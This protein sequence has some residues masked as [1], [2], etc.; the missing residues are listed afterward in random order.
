MA[1]RRLEG[2]LDGEGVGFAEI[3]YGD[4]DRRGWIDFI[5][6]GHPAYDLLAHEAEQV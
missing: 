6:Y 4:L 2:E 5:L 1:G 3:V